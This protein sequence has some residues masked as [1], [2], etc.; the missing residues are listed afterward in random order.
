MKR[1]LLLSVLALAACAHKPEV[2]AGPIDPRVAP[3]VPAP[4]HGKLY[5]DCLGAAV[6]A[7]SYE[8]DPKGDWMRFNCTGAPARAFYEGLAGRS[9]KV[10]S[11]MVAD[12]R[13]WR[14]TNKLQKD[15]VGADVCS[16]SAS[17]DYKCT[18]ILNVGEFLG[19]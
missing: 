15:A 6:S 5:A 4:P 8:K 1:T 7:Q 2:A 3:G 13:T 18:I 9:A 16:T 17:G 12:G 19:Q 14:F 11:E 10:G